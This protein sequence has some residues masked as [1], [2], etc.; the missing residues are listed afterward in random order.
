MRNLKKSPVPPALSSDAQRLTTS[1]LTALCEGNAK[2]A[3]WRKKAIREALELETSSRCAYCDAEIVQVAFT[4]IEH[5]RPRDLYPTQVL[6]WSNL[7]ISCQKCNNK[8][9]D[10]F[11]HDLPFISPFDDDPTAHFVHAGA[12]MFAPMSD[13]GKHT[14]IKLGLNDHPLRRR[15]KRLET[16][17]AYVSIWSKA[18]AALKPAQ[19]SFIRSDMEDGEYRETVRAFLRLCAFPV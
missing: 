9:S 14:I 17:D 13:R 2:P 19:E 12:I 6:N 18:P 4:H 7:T 15:E 16:V 10:D 5:F 3:V 1:Y 8:K 11:D